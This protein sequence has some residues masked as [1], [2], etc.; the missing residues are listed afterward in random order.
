MFS[1]LLTKRLFSIVLLSL[2]VNPCM[3]G[4]P[5]TFDSIG[6]TYDD[7]THFYLYRTLFMQARAKTFLGPLSKGSK[8]VVAGSGQVGTI[9]GTAVIHREKID[10]GDMVRFTQQE[11]MTGMPTFGDQS[12]RRGDYLAYRNLEARVNLIKSPAVPIQGEMAIQRVKASIQNIPAAVRAEVIK[13]MAEE[14]EYEAIVS[15]L[16]GASKSCLIPT[17]SGGLGVTLGIGGT[18]GRPLMPMNFYTTDTGFC[19]YSATGS[20]YNSTVNDAINGIDAAA[21]D[22][23][24]LTQIDIICDKFD[25]LNWGSVFLNSRKY[26]AVALCDTAIWYRLRNLLKTDWSAAMERGKMNPIFN[27]DMQLEY[28]DILWLPVTNLAKFRAAYNSGDGYPTFGAG[29]YTDP[30]TYTSSSTNALVVFCGNKAILEGYNGMIEVRE[31]KGY[32][33]D[34]HELAARM[35]LG[36]MRG[37]WFATDGRTDSSAY[38]CNSLIVA[39]FYEP[40]VGV[41]YS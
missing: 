13:Y 29:L 20:T 1:N 15:M 38:Y 12:H 21:A 34:G 17:S 25:K 31:D 23:I 24:S 40:G 7:Q 6:G 5:G 11:H 10:S 8:D 18:A 30:R 19:T 27:I 14:M 35:K 3:A 33:G 39:A 32:M 36:Y 41:N 37:E 9:D 28:K 4:G 2:M 22:S 16:Y 26:K